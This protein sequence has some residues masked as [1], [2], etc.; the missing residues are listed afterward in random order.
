MQKQLSANS[1]VAVGPMEE[2]FF[3]A[4]RHSR[5]SPF[6]QRAPACAKASRPRRAILDLVRARL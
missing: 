4:A 5:L 2:A 3:C 1:N 6:V